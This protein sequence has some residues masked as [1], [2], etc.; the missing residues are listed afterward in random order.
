MTHSLTLTRDMAATP[1]KVWRCLTEP[2]LLAQWFAP[3][4]V[5]VTKAVIDPR[6]GGAF[7]VV[8]H[9]PEMGDMDG[10]AGCVLEAVPEQRM[11]WTS[12]LAP[13]FG[14]NPAPGDG[15]FHFTAIMTL[16]P[17]VTGTRY[18]A[19]ALHADEAAKNAHAAM[20][21]HDGWGTT[22]DQLGALA[23]RL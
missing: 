2:D 15:A 22:A 17:T 5:T 12:A 13:G 19:T 3:D 7:H 23:A 20:G 18:T 4:P 14:P 1:A 6:P 10:G 16:E 21:F 11:V 9:V 8:M